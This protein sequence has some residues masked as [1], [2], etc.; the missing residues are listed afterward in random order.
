MYKGKP[1]HQEATTYIAFCSLVCSDV[2][3]F[4]HGYQS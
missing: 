2:D 1:G 3:S 4:G